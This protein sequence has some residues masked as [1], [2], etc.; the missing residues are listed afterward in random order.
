MIRAAPRG[1]IVHWYTAGH[2]LDAAAYRDAFAWLVRK[3][4]VGG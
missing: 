2:P 1:T 3:L 4:R